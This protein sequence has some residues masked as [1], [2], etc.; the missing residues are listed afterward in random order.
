VLQFSLDKFASLLVEHG[1]GLL[2]GVQ[3]AAYNSHSASFVP[4]MFG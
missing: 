1:N 4:S 2:S 3:I